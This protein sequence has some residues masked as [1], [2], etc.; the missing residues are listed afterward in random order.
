[1]AH[2]EFK[3]LTV[4]TGV[5]VGVLGYKHC[6]SLLWGTGYLRGEIRSCTDIGCSYA[7]SSAAWRLLVLVWA[8]LWTLLPSQWHR[9]P[10]VP[11]F[12]AFLETAAPDISVDRCE[13]KWWCACCCSVW[14]GVPTHLLE[15]MRLASLI[16]SVVP[17]QWLWPTFFHLDFSLEEVAAVSDQLEQ[18]SPMF[19]FCLWSSV[20]IVVI[21]SHEHP[22]GPSLRGSSS[23]WIV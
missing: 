12:L 17:G 23:F 5:H 18:K 2:V 3:R 22:Q 16:S 1:M 20:F 9:C 8:M 14:T 6:P 10:G 4:A 7:A 19:W 13:N 11:P 21:G 15:I